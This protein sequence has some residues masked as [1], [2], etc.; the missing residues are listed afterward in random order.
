MISEND[1]LTVFE[2]R[3]WISAFITSK[4]PAH[5]FR[6]SGEIEDLTSEIVIKI[7]KGLPR[8]RDDGR[9]N[10]RTWM[11]SIIVNH[12]T[13]YFRQKT[14]QS[15][16]H[17]ASESLFDDLIDH[18]YVIPEDAFL[19][20]ERIAG[21]YSKMSLLNQAQRTVIALLASESEFSYEDIAEQTEQS[22]AAVK[23]IIYRARSKMKKLA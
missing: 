1:F 19:Q 22:V 21:L 15:K 18:H 7:A 14:N 3:H 2:E 16:R 8:F 23:S 12:V 13:S 10:L 6:V 20:K 9:A 5:S 4:F 17:I 11:G